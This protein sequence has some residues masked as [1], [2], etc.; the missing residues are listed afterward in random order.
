MTNVNYLKHRAA[1]ELNGAQGLSI[2]G[3]PIP[4][5]GYVNGLKQPCLMFRVI[6]GQVFEKRGQS[7]REALRLADQ[8][9]RRRFSGPVAEAIPRDNDV[10]IQF[11]VRWIRLILEKSDHPVLQEPKVFGPHKNQPPVWTI[12]QPCLDFKAAVAA[13]EVCVSLLSWALQK[14]FNS[15]DANQLLDEVL[16][17][18]PH[19]TSK[20]WTTEWI[21]HPTLFI[22]RASTKHP[23]VSTVGEYFS[24]GIWCRISTA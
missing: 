15:A 8:V 21:Q 22:C 6:L 19:A 14:P 12:L 23:L 20:E 3:K 4:V 9:M 10:R 18:V 17:Y 7:N 2:V 1:F 24:V 11:L 16:L 5:P 13:L